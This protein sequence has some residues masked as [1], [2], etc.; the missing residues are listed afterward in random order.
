MRGSN[1]AL[2]LGPGEETDFPLQEAA[3]YGNFFDD[4]DTGVDTN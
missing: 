4:G 3:F 1:S 2:V